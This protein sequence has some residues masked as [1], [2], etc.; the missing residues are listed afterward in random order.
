MP[1][2]KPVFYWDSPIFISW[3]QDEKR[4]PG[5][6]EGVYELAEKFEKKEI[7]LVTSVT[8]FTE[9]LE[10]RITAEA[11]KIFENFFKR[12]NAI[13]MNIDA[14]IATL[15]RSIRGYYDQRGKKLS[16]PDSQHLASAI[17]YRVDEMHTFDEDDLLPLNGNVADHR[18]IICKPHT[19]QLRFE[20][21]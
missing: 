2:R 16:T 12:R 11:A 18:L 1:A 4:K 6:M 5:E 21:F 19:P 8:T 15:A 3:L 7:I 14:R 10:T 13:L 9:V 17:H 20:G